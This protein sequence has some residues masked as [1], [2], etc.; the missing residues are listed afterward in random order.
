MHDD[1]TCYGKKAPGHNTVAIDRR[2]SHGAYRRSDIETFASELPGIAVARMRHHFPY[3]MQDVP[4]QG[5]YR[6]TIIHNAI[7]LDH[8]YVLDL[9]EV[10]GGTLH[11]YFLHG[12]Y[13]F[14]QQPARDGVS[15]NLRSGLQPLSDEA[16]GGGNP[17]YGRIKSLVQGPLAEKGSVDFR[18]VDKP[19]HGSRTHLFAD[20]RTRLILGDGE[21]IQGGTQVINGGKGIVAKTFPQIVLR[22]E[23]SLGERTVFVVIHEPFHDSSQIKSYSKRLLND[24]NALSVTVNTEDGRTD[25]YPVSLRFQKA[26]ITTEQLMSDG[27]F[28]AN[29]VIAAASEHGSKKDLWLVDGSRVNLGDR[30]LEPRVP[31]VVDANILEIQRGIYYGEPHSLLTNAD[32]PVGS[33][34]AGQTLLLELSDEKGIG[35]NPPHGF[36]VW[37]MDEQRFL[38]LL[39][40][41][42]V[43]AEGK[44][45]RR[46]FVRQD[47]GLVCCTTPGIRP[48]RR[49]RSSAWMMPRPARGRWS[50]G[51]PRDR[52]PTPFR[53]SS[54]G[55]SRRTPGILA[56]T[57]RSIR[58]KR[59]S[60]M[61]MPSPANTACV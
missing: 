18:F 26:E 36:H 31:N 32:L 21:A 28:Q 9:F 10:S 30:V 12:A 7:D 61:H 48:T 34:L 50:D 13:Q 44:R 22:R 35:V 52:L 54:L 40:I 14:Q 29:A 59:R 8:P 11:D 38:K 23:V 20:A 49:A 19:D 1:C 16:F 58:P 25:R 45:K 27:D 15:A 39:T 4:D 53:G 3:R 57:A 41:D 17:E 51:T 46:V 24:G 6:R 60:L 5:I 2:S 56:P 37:T 55:L 47:P 42:H 33:D 43:K